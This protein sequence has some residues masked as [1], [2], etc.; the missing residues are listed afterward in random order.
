MSN[1]HLIHTI[2]EVVLIALVLIGVFYEPV[3]AKWEE[4]QKEKVLKAFKNR[5][6][7][8]GERKNVNN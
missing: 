4:K 7:F 1:T 5:R 3:V 6:K 2:V 8:R